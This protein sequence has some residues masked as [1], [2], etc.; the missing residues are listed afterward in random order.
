M[1]LF[2]ELEEKRGL[3]VRPI[4]KDW[5]NELGGEIRIPRAKRI[6]LYL[7]KQKILMLCKNMI[8]Q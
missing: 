3:A 5:P 2:K 7:Y 8:R 4:E 1:G 6:F